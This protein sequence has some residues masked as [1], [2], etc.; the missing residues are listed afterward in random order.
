MEPDHFHDLINNICANSL[1]EDQIFWQPLPMELRWSWTNV[2]TKQMWN[3]KL[4]QIKSIS[5]INNPTHV[6]Y[7]DLL[8]GIKTAFQAKEQIERLNKLKVFW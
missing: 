2:R 5:D 6:I 1:I 4:S 8:Y 3:I 7:M